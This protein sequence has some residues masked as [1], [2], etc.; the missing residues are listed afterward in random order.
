MMTEE[1]QLTR[2]E[3]EVS[4]EQQKNQIF[5]LTNQIEEIQTNLTD[6]QTQKAGFLIRYLL[7]GVMG[8]LYGL[9]MFHF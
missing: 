9:F 5:I 1:E 8:L 6:T 3:M 7:Y 2:K 4:I